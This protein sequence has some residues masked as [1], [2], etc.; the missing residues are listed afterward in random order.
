MSKTATIISEGCL[1]ELYLQRQQPP[2]HL[3]LQILA[4]QVSECNP[5]EIMYFP[6]HTAYASP[7]ERPSLIAFL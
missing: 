3:F 5:K 7:M 4:F 1:K 6:T 2:N